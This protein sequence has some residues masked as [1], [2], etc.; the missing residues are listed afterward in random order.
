M[1]PAEVAEA[2]G[3]Q[4]FAA[5]LQHLEGG[6]PSLANAIAAEERDLTSFLARMDH[7]QETEGST[8]TSLHQ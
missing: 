7:I 6:W 3:Y 8:I 2:N 4:Q 5:L 1:T